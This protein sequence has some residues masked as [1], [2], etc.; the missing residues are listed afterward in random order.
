MFTVSSF[1]VQGCALRGGLKMITSKQWAWNPQTFFAASVRYCS[2]NKTAHVLFGFPAVQV[3]V[4]CKHQGI[5]FYG[6]SETEC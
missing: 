4:F 6:P 3:G 5:C 1:Q 2:E